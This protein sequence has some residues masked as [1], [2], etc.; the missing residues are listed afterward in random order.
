MLSVSDFVGVETALDPR[1]VGEEKVAFRSNRAGVP[2]VFVVSGAGG[3]PEQVTDT[4]GVV[5]AID[6]RPGHDQL[7]FVTDV[8]GDEQYGLHLLDLDSGDVQSLMSEPDVIFNHGAWS[9]DGRLLSYAS[10][11]RTREHFDIYVLNVELGVE[12]CVWSIDA[13]PRAGCF[14][15]DSSVL[16]AEVPNL[17]VG[18]DNDLFAVQLNQDGSPSGPA[19]LLLTAHEADPTSPAQ[20]TSAVVHGSGCVIA[21]CDEDREFMAIQRIEADGSA[22]EVIVE[23]DWDIEAFSL[24]HEN[25]R[26]AVVVNEDGYSRVEALRLDHEGRPGGSVEMA[27]TPTGVIGAPVWTRSGDALL[28]SL[29]GARHPSH[30]WSAPIGE[31]AAGEEAHQ[32]VASETGIVDPSLLAEPQLVSYPTFDGRQIPGY[33]FRPADSGPSVPCLVIVHG[34]PEAQSRPSLWA[35]SAAQLLMTEGVAVFV[36]NVRGSTG[37][38][39]EYEHAD[40]REKRMDSVRDLVACTDWLV[41]SAGIDENRIGVVGQSYGGFMVLA[42]ITEAPERWAMA[43]DL[44]GIANFET[45][46]EFTGPWRRR[47]R[48]R[49]YGDDP[50]LLRSISPIHKAD[51]ITC[52]LLVIQGDRDV[53][54]PQEESEQIVETVRG[55]GGLVEFVVYPDEGHGIQKLAHRLDMGERFVEFARRHLLGRS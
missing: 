33:L 48:A 46:M 9:P 19:A 25:S 7:L 16:L 1:A 43:V 3:D 37:Y 34:G 4:E 45:F 28:F 40:D 38:G 20:W 18:G 47:H 31:G 55:N 39:K 27:S 23:R 6:P 21:L 42:A 5:Y 15:S 26:L 2:Q 44:Y 29:M 52:P 50:E 14:N 10:N 12:H 13:M 49:E 51:R 36:P 24:D 17:E 41:H 35:Q 30:V 32:L 53:R 8:G 54:V 11:R 22:R